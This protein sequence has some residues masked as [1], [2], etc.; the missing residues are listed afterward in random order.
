MYAPF[1]NG[2]S[3]GQVQAMVP[4]FHDLNNN[5]VDSMMVIK[6]ADDD[7]E[8]GYKLYYICTR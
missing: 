7:D 5:L 1:M 6:M 3:H 8:I 4:S 2:V